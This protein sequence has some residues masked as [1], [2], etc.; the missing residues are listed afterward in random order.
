MSPI[1]PHSKEAEQFFLSACLIDGAS[2]LVDALSQD[3]TVSMFYFRANQ[4]IYS[5][6]RTMLSSSKTLDL[7]VLVEELKSAGEFELIGGFP[8]LM[9]VS[10]LNPTMAKSGYF[11]QKIRELH[12]LR[13]TIRE[14]QALIEICTSGVDDIQE[15]LAKPAERIMS[16]AAG[17]AIEREPSFEEL[18]EEADRVR[19]TMMSEG[20]RPKGVILNFPWMQMDFAF[21]PMQR[22]QLIV[23]GGRPSTGKSSLA[24]QM[25]VHTAMQ[26]FNVYFVTLEVNPV[27][28]VLNLAQTLARVGI[29]ELAKVGPSQQESFS[30]A[31]KGMKK[32]GFHISRRDRTLAQILAK[33]K[34]IHAR[35]PL[36]MVCVDYGGLIE[37]IAGAHK[38]DKIVQIG[39][40]TKAL[41]KLAGDLNCVVLLPWQLNRDSAKDGNRQPQL[42]ELRD[43][44]DL[45]QDADKVIFVHRPSNNDALKR[46]QSD[47]ASRYEQ[48]SFYM[49]LIQA[50]GRDDGTGK[51]NMN[52]ERAYASF[53]TLN[54]APAPQPD[55]AF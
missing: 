6:L 39:R 38:N 13:E 29:K 30:Q 35:A 36:A 51:M 52:F 48:P 40:V 37:D 5:R 41:K 25:A 14:A 21:E 43:S 33:A 9:E 7:A 28:V 19:K 8:Y 17:S 54:E 20:G 24:R 42:H 15:A 10:A 53:A 31:L 2:A 46:P 50:K 44:G 16:L 45:E 4:V 32:L 26:G 18:I 22:G 12:T 11:A 1:P 49:D 55:L 47:T 3:L 27:Q 34:S 23:V